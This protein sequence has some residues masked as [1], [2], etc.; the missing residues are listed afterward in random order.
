MLDAEL[1]TQVGDIMWEAHGLHL[2]G[3]PEAAIKRYQD[4]LTLMGD[5]S[6]ASIDATTIYCNIG[7]VYWLQKSYDKSLYYLGLAVHN[8]GGLGISI[9]HLRIGQIRY[10]QGELKKAQ[11]ELTRAYVGG[12]YS[13]FEEEDPKYYAL[14][15]PHIERE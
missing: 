14:I 15:Q 10:E 4:A 5:K 11:D 3:Q 1:L 8:E 2:Q 9:I 13:V 7:E 12:G 6:K